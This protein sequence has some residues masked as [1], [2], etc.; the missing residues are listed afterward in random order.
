MT[1]KNI[2]NKQFFFGCGSINSWEF[3]DLYSN[4]FMVKRAKY[5]SIEL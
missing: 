3:V 5:Q 2:I 1:I 4:V